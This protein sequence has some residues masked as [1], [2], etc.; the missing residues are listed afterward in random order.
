MSNNIYLQGFGFCLGQQHSMNELSFLKQ[1]QE[2]QRRFEEMGFV[3]FLYASES[4]IDLGLQA[5]DAC[6]SSTQTDPKDI[7]VVIWCSNT[8]DDKMYYR[9]LHQGFH[10][11][12][13][14]NAF[15]IGVH[16]TF[17]GNLGTGIRLLRSLFIGGGVRNALLVSTDKNLEF[18]E[19]ARLLEP[20]V[21]VTSDGASCMKFSSETGGYRL[22][23]IHQLV[24]HSMADLEIDDIYEGNLRYKP[25]FMRYSLESFKGRKRAADEYYDKTRT[26]SDDYTWIVT[27]NYGLNTVKGFASESGMPLDKLFSANIPRTGHIQGTDN[28]L[29]LATLDN[30]IGLKKGD[31]ILLLSTGPYSWGY[32]SVTRTEENLN[33][34]IFIGKPIC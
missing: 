9:D 8:L 29:N 16:G 18:D 1:D 13:L 31:R 30:E 6:L 5:I 3:N 21:A 22:E 28:A 23:G 17:C 11:R 7:E 2:R 25:S 15:P 24:N 27:N 12:L 33:K 14:S 32:W 10:Q 34:P 4:A 26:S 20:G 19:K